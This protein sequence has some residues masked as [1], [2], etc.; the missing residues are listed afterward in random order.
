MASTSTSL[1]T[2]GTMLVWK[3]WSASTHLSGVRVSFIAGRFEIGEENWLMGMW[4]HGVGVYHTYDDCCAVQTSLGEARGGGG[5]TELSDKW[6]IKGGEIELVGTLEGWD[7]KQDDKLGWCTWGTGTSEWLGTGTSEWLG[8]GTSEW[9]GTGTSEWWVQVHQ[10]GG[11]K[12]HQSGG[13]QN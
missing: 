9:W 5:G 1:R 10:S 11:L 4:K 3:Y 7:T 12:I 13:V 8:T 2:A 6:R